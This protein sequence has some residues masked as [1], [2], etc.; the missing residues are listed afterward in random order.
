M[1]LMKG[2][3][4]Q[5]SVRIHFRVNAAGGGLSICNIA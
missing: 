4:D 3:N 1:N 5:I 2:E